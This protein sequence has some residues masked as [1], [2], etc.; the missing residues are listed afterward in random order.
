MVPRKGIGS[1]QGDQGTQCPA[2]PETHPQVL[3]R[4]VQNLIDNAL[5]YGGSAEAALRTNATGAVC[6]DVLDRGPRIPEE[7]L[8]AVLQPFRRLEQSRGRA[9]GGMGLGLA[10]VQ[11]L[12][13]ALG[14]KLHLR[15]RE[16]GGL[17]ATVELRSR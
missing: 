16:G 2:G 10:I 11:Q 13:H 7:S 15:N 8:E 1:R 6:I 9:T 5:A 14:G 3:R 17:W 4:I 12:T